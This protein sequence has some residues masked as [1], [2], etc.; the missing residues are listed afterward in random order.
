MPLVRSFATEFIPL[1]DAVMLLS[2]FPSPRH[3]IV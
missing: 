1:F 3:L 2:T